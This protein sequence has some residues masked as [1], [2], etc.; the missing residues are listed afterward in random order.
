M[1]CP[2]CGSHRLYKDGL[3]YLA[4]GTSIQRWLCRNCGYR[5]TNPNHKK[6][7]QWKNPPFSLNPPNSSD[8]NCQ[9]NDDPCGRDSTAL[10]AVQ[11]LATVEKQNEKRDAGVTTLVVDNLASQETTTKIVEYS[12]WLLKQGYS[13]ATI[14]GRVKLL[15][16]L[17]N[18]GA[19]LFDPE[20]IKEVISK[21]ESWSEG[22]KELAVEA[23]SSFLLMVGGK[24]D[25]PKYRRVQKLPFI[26]T[27]EELDQLIA[28]CG[29][30]T[31][32]FLQLLKETGMR[33]GEAWRLKWTD[34][35]LVNLN[36]RVTPEK[37]SNPRILK[38]SQNLVAMLNTLHKKSELIFGE[39]PIRG[40]AR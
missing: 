25:P 12:F 33:A 27:E 3:R 32:T 8:Y 24:W 18:L 15:K 11:T 40:F 14:E 5:F 7:T 19:H 4:N 34:V 35:D 23:Y 21:Q 26:P 1:Q 28:S 36:V 38:I 37:G 17:V 16:R 22:R 29:K 13:K 39:Y 2:Q 31:A 30:K 20:S 6:H 9:G 10:A